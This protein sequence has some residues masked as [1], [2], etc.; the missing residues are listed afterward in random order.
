[1]TDT[2]KSDNSAVVARLE[3]RIA[4]LEREL[5]NEQRKYHDLRVGVEAAQAEQGWPPGA[6]LARR[7]ARVAAEALDRFARRFTPVGRT[8]VVL[9]NHGD[10]DP[11]DADDVV[12]EAEM[13]ARELRREAEGDES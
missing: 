5:D 8:G 11:I 9:E 1:M 7:D 10:G 6:A 12:A 3:K 4:E 13:E 2:I